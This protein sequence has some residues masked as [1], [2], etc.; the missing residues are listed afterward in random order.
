M[1]KLKIY[2]INIKGKK[3]KGLVDKK[4]INSK[5]KNYNFKSKSKDKKEIIEKTKS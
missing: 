3:R 4:S 1:I 5:T 2:L